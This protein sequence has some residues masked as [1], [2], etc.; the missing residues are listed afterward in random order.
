MV[1]PTSEENVLVISWVPLFAKYVQSS[2]LEF[3]GVVVSA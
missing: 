3:R 2:D 1:V